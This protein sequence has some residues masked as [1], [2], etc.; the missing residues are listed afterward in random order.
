[1]QFFTTMFGVVMTET[2]LREALADIEK[3]KAEHKNRYV[4]KPGDRYT[5]EGRNVIYTAICPTS[6]LVKNARRAFGSTGD[7]V[8]YT[9][10]GYGLA[11][12]HRKS[13]TAFTK[14]SEGW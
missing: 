11:T 9:V 8:V 3:Q 12:S 2:A 13:T 5:V 14:V 1:M 4:P 10:D 6:A 7:D